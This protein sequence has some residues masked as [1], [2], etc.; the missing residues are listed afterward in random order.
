MLL[1][2]PTVKR[3]GDVVYLSAIRECGIGKGSNGVVAVGVAADIG[4][5]GSGD[6]DATKFSNLSVGTIALASPLCSYAFMLKDVLS[7]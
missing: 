7:A 6:A 1:Y 3:I 4:G 2:A 5:I